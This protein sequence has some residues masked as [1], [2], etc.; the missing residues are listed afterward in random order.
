M[1]VRAITHGNDTD[2]RNQGYAAYY[3]ATVRN[4][5]AVEKH[6]EFREAA[7]IS[8]ILDFRAEATAWL[9]F[10]T[11]S[12]KRSSNYYENNRTRVEGLGPTTVLKF[13][14]SGQRSFTQT[15][16]NN[17][18]QHLQS[19]FPNQKFVVGYGARKPICFVYVQ[20]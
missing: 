7:H 5:E 10:N 1:T 12:T 19:I 2:D 4:L 17:L 16:A 13:D 18:D 20:L 3:D 11:R 15:D 8:K 14:L 6:P 9:G